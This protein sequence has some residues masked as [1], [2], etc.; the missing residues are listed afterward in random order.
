MGDD[1]GTELYLVSYKFLVGT[2]IH[3]CTVTL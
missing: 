3:Q 2:F 1:L